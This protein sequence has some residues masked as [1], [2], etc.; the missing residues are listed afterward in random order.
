MKYLLIDVYEN[1]VKLVDCNGLYDMY[2]YI[3]CNFIDV[4]LR[5]VDGMPISI[6]CDDAALCKVNIPLLS[7][8][9]IFD[10][11]LYGNI[12]IASARYSDGDYCELNNLELLTV[13]QID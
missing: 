9:N 1:A 6:V 2:K 10:N 11:H 12:L 7:A 8:S 13:I 5:Y 3:R 4:V